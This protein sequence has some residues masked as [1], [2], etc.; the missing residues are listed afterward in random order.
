MDI[1]SSGGQEFTMNLISNASMATF[2][3][4]TLSNFTTL[5]PTT[6]SL[7]GDWQ[8]ALVEIAWPAMVQNVTLGQFTVSKQLPASPK[9]KNSR[10][11]KPG[12][13][14]M[15]VPS[16]FIQLPKYSSPVTLRLKPGCYPSV[17]SIMK[18]ITKAAMGKKE[19]KLMENDRS[20]DSMLSWKID[21][22]TRR[23]HVKSNCIVGNEGLKITVVSEDLKNILGTDVIIDCQSQQRRDETEAPDQ[24]VSGTANVVKQIG[25][26]PV[27]LNAGSHT[28]FLYCDLVQNEMLGDTQTALLRS[29]PLK[30]MTLAHTMGEVNHKSFTNLQWKRIVKPQFQSISLTLANEMGQKMPFL[31]C[32]R[33]NI[34]L[35]FRPA[36]RN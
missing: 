15:T 31:S 28:M 8:V 16:G 7:P 14:S 18:A 17:D 19:S 9:E 1:S 20:N 10:H 27:D 24:L 30:S 13:I 23:L 3:A 25:Q 21:G 2:P 5:L 35:A 34:T 6:M 36:P 12:L 33:T 11:H 4:N 29:I 26:W 22:V 32:G